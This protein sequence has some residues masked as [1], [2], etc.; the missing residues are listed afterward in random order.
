MSGDTPTLFKMK[1]LW[2]FWITSFVGKE[3]YL[4]KIR[5][6]QNRAEYIQIVSELLEV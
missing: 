5:K 3:K 2:G 1:E 4:K 6:V